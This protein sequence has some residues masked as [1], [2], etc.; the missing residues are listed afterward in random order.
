MKKKNEFNYYE[1]FEKSAILAENAAK[2]LK[3]YIENFN[4]ETSESEKIKIHEIEHQ[5]DNNL[6]EIKKYLL[7]DFLPPIDREDIVAISHKIDDLVDAIDEI[8]INLDIL[9]INEITEEMKKFV[10]ELEKTVGITRELVS[11]MK[12]LKNNEQIKAKVIEINKLEE[13][14]DKIYENAI[15]NLYKNEQDPIKVIKWSN[16]YGCLENCFDA[17]ENI[18]DC[19]EEVLLKNC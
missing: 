6:H 7:R 17:C 15:R 5:A 16:M 14:G 2:E 12:N 3:N 13:D 8:V 10:A 18:A 4:S 1:H 9:V 19:V 11:V